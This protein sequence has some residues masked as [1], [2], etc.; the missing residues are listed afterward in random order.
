MSKSNVFQR[1]ISAGMHRDLPDHLRKRIEPTNVIAL[2]IAGVIGIPFSVISV[3]YFPSLAIYPESGG[4]LCAL[5]VL[6][7]YYGGIRFTRFI[8]C[9]VPITLGAIYN[10]H[11]SGVDDDP[12][13]ALYLIELSFALI[14]FVIFDLKEKWSIVAIT[15][16]CSIIIL[17]FPI[18]KH[19]FNS[20]YDSTVLRSGWL[21]T[22]TI[23]IAIL[24]EFGCVLGLAFISK[25]AEK[26]SELAKVE[27]EE[28]N[29]EL[30][31]N[32][33]KLA[34]NLK[35]VEE[36]QEDERKRNWASEGI[37]GI[38]EILRSTKNSSKIYD[39]IVSMV[40]SYMDANQGG[41]FIVERDEG[42]ETETIKMASCYAYTRKKFIETEYQ[43]G[44][45]LIGQAYLEKECI[46]LTDIPQNYVK[47]TS[48]LGESTPT[49][50]IIMPLMVNEMVEGL[51][52]IASFDAF[53]EHEVAFLEK[54]GE[55]IA[56]FIQTNRINER[57]SVLLQEAQER[58]EELRAQEEEM[59]QNM[60]ELAA[61]QEEMQR[62][63]R[64]YQKIIDELKSD[65][66][67]LEAGSTV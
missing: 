20:E 45:G 9:L 46:H 3:I 18:T 19:W 11:L 34:E 15:L 42:T 63:E 21:S 23:L 6:L 39:D 22:L 37:A 62:K 54:L 50:L 47:I 5:C 49:S 1:V 24:S 13:P 51:I 12:L 64:E 38:A 10:S 53:Q 67:S 26:E 60:E 48:G 16:T 56:S 66:S 27:A 40:V 14:P 28:K 61:T 17:A 35:K 59:R 52:E 30:E 32:Q 29:L 44:Q 36:A 41:L 58:A 55:S 43:P 33:V 65:K 57:T 2:I 31:E 4:A 8:I 7:N 25:S